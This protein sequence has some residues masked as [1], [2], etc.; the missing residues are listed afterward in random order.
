MPMHTTHAPEKQM[1]SFFQ[2]FPQ[3]FMVDVMFF[4]ADA[5][6]YVKLVYFYYVFRNLLT[7]IHIT[8]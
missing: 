7:K 3:F 4:M 6:F 5:P 1:H 8:F 2:I